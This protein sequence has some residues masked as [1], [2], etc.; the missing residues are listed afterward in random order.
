MGLVII[1]EKCVGCRLCIKACPFGALDLIDKKAVV[2]EKCTLCG[3]CV[4]SC[5]FDAIVLPERDRTGHVNID[6]Y[7]GV[8][9]FVQEDGGGIHHV[10]LE[11]VGEGRKLAD[12]L[13]THLSC[14]VMGEGIEPLLDELSH[15][16]VDRMYAVEHPVLARYRTKPFVAA[17]VA[18][19]TR[20]K[21]EIVLIGAT[22]TGRDFG[23]GLATELRTGLTADCTDLDI[24][25]ETRSLLQTRPAFGG[26]IMATIKSSRHRPQM[27]T[28][29]PKVFAMPLRG[30]KRAIEVVREE[31]SLSE[32]DQM[33]RILE[34]IPSKEGV[35]LA[36][37]NIIVSGGRGIGKPENF[38]LLQELAELLGGAVGASRAVVDAGWIDYSHQ[39]GQTG[40]TVRPTVYIACGISGA[41]QH[42][43]GMKTSEVIIAI[44][45]DP[46][47]PIF[48]VATYGFVGDVLEIVPKLIKELKSRRGLA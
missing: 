22:A 33:T 12:R 43:A 34:W 32:A 28:V 48:K 26:N 24:E 31:V 10:S 35:N 45:R 8:W 20:Y 40:R 11:L 9:V 25:D 1:K 17:S 36:D 2:N 5:K 39:V 21:P 15:Y 23:G 47:A 42:I 30:E 7:H 41:V 27:A 13:G 37:A 4:S 29:R 14:M 44:N 18:L 6:E 19:I 16:P 3:I 46:D 38:S